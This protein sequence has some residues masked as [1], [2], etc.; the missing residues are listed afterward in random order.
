MTLKARLASFGRRH[1]FEAAN[2]A[3]FLAA[4]SYVLA[5]RAMAGLTGLGMMDVCLMMLNVGFMARCAELV[6]IH[7]LR[8]C[9]LGN[10]RSHLRE[11]LLLPVCRGLNAV[12]RG[13]RRIDRLTAKSGHSAR[14]AARR[15]AQKHQTDEPG[16]NRQA[17]V[18]LTFVGRRK[19]EFSPKTRPE[20]TAA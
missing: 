8:V 12:R 13:N 15:R 16:G 9:K 4:S 10:S 5:P 7:H 18:A 19:H 2:Q 3:G 1:A 14:R 6:I 17:H 11:L 20:R